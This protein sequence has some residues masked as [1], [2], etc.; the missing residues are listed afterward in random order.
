[1]IPCQRHL[2][3][4]PD[5]IAYFNCGYMSPQLKSV[6]DAG[7]AG[8]NIKSSPWTL[9]PEDFF[10]QPDKA[11]SLFAQ[12]INAEAK[13]IAIVPSASYGLAIAAKN[14]KI[15]A[16]QKI[17]VL[18]EQFPSNIYCWQ[19]LAKQTGA[20][21]VTVKTPSDHNWTPVVLD[22]IDDTVTVAALPHCHWTDGALLD[23][24]KISM[25]LKSHGAKLVLDITQSIGALPID[26][27]RVKPDFLVAACYKWMLGPY[28]LGFV[29]A[30]PEFQKGEPIEH[31]WINRAGSENF[32]GLVDYQSNYQPGAKRFDM[33]QRANFSLMPMAIA[34]L[35]Q[36]LA[37]GCSNIQQTL[38][39]M[40]DGIANSCKELGFTPLPRQFRAGHFLGLRH[41]EGLPKDLLERLMAKDIYISV[42]GASLRVTPHLFNNDTDAERLISALSDALNRR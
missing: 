20:E 15:A 28:S 21:I 30:A 26:V 5:H 6:R 42:R 16:G 35:E 22:A 31:N 23:L 10:S 40:T 27:N 7:Y 2:F 32:A 38:C 14:I 13:D 37:W 33:G 36:L 11:R 34:A 17:L 24:E 25:K 3:D 41:S 39:E 1:M 29:Y 12:L 8:V 19:E 4:I 18:D 9:T